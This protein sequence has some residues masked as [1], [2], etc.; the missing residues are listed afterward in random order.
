MPKLSR[1]QVA[2]LSFGLGVAS[3]L[4]I[5]LI[6]DH[7]LSTD[8]A[9]QV[10][11][12]EGED[13]NEDITDGQGSS[14]QDRRSPTSHAIPSDAMAHKSME[15]LMDGLRDDISLLKT[16]VKEIRAALA[17]KKPEDQTSNRE[18]PIKT[19]TEQPPSDTKTKSTLDSIAP[20]TCQR[21]ARISSWIHSES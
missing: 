12:K 7:V 14:L 6:L 19:P 1:N 20:R 5:E 21:R 8:I 16:S 10:T 3:T 17:M 2:I 15:E 11:R 18:H 4:A 9:S 13:G